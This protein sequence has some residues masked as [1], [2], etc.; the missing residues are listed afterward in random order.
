MAGRCSHGA[1]QPNF[2]GILCLQDCCLRRW[3]LPSDAAAPR[4]TRP[5]A[6]HCRSYTALAGTLDSKPS[7]KTPRHRRFDNGLSSSLSAP[8]LRRC[9]CGAPALHP[10]AQASAALARPS[11][12][13]VTHRGVEGEASCPSRT[14]VGMPRRLS[15]F[16]QAPFA[17]LASPPLYPIPCPAPASSS[18]YT[19]LPAAVR[20]RRAPATQ[21]GP[22]PPSSW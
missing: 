2:K 18:P 21:P 19:H 15:L 6:R 9:P 12:A 3:P 14:T 5:S 13:K 22:P 16:L 17:H 20:S 10:A 7:T 1:L 11:S 4:V 8:Q